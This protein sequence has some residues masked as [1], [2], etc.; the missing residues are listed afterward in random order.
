MIHSD[1]KDP[2]GP[3][4]KDDSPDKRPAQGQDHKTP[5]DGDGGPGR[6]NPGGPND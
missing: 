4:G 3:A 5:K 6:G 2:P 1:P